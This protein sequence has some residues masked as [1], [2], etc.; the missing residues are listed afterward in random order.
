MS[1]RLL[2]G[3]QLNV[4]DKLISNNG[5][6]QLIMQADGNVVLYRTDDGLAL[7]ASNT[8]GQPVTHAI[9]QQDGNFVAYDNAGHAHWSS[10]TWNNPGAWL[11]LQDDGNL[12]IYSLSNAPLWATNTVQNWPAPSDR[13]LPGQQLNVNE[14]IV[15]ASGRVEL[16]MQADGNVVLYRTDNNTAL[17]ASA[18]SGKP[19]THAIMQNDGNF[20]AY[21]AGGHAYWDSGTWNNPGAWL[22]AQNDGNLVVYSS[23]NAPLWASNT[24]QNWSIKTITPQNVNLGNGHYMVSD[25]E[26]DPSANNV[27]VNVHLTNTNKIFG[28]TGAAKVLFYGSDG[29]RLGSDQRDYGVNPAPLIG[30]THRDDTWTTQAPPGTEAFALSQYWDPHNRINID[31]GP[32]SQAIDNFFTDAATFLAKSFDPNEWCNQNPGNCGNLVFVAFVIGATALCLSGVLGP[33][34]LVISVIAAPAA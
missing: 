11:V 26:L 29:K 34:D 32:L 9:M 12:V 23:L 16:I 24:V 2:P 18:T 31:L 19:V 1:D 33:C 7:W 22:V 21:D 13:L 4:N 15:S 25:A 28:F 17:W 30:A 6:V 27:V 8:W 20:V 3:Q 14:K 5:R 10:N